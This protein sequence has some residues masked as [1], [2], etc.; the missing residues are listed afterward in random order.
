MMSRFASP[1]R[2]P[3]KSADRHDRT[4]PLLPKEHARQ[5]DLS[6]T[7]RSATVCRRLSRNRHLAFFLQR[8]Y[9]RAQSWHH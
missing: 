9:M 1:L 3:R 8:A 2:A 5:C 7:F 6:V 4:A